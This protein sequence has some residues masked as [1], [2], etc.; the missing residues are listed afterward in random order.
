MIDWVDMLDDPDVPVEHILAVV[1]LCLDDLV[2]NLE[3]PAEPLDGGLARS[4]WVENPLKGCVQF[5][6]AERTPVHWTEDLHV[7][8]RVQSKPLWNPLLHQVDQGCR[9]FLWIVPLDEMKVGTRVSSRSSG[10]CP[11]R[12]RCALAMIWLCTACRNTPR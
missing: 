2:A 12:I 10:I 3:S 5:A 1:I 7:A 8:D 11:R 9:N 6:Y 4:V